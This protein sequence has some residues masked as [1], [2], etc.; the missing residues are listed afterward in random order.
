[1]LLNRNNVDGKVKIGFVLFFKCICL[2]IICVLMFGVKFGIFTDVMKV[3][4]Y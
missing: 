2:F 3:F 4:Y 1:M